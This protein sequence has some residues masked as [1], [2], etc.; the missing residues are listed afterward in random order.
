M[1]FVK[2]SY[3]EKMVDN[4]FTK[5]EK[6]PR[7]LKKKDKEEKKIDN[8]GKILVVSTHGRDEK[9]TKRWLSILKRVPTTSS[10]LF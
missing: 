7:E 9:L 5:I 1:D 6:L 8:D 2:C 3:P 10:L 4:I